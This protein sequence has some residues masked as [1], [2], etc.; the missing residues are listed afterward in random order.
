[1]AIIKV[2]EQYAGEV[3]TARSPSADKNLIERKT[4]TPALGTPQTE[5]FP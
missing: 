5:E 3:S 4:A 1:M 2:I